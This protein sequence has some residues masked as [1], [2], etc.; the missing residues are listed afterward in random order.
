MVLENLD[1]SPV[2]A[3]EIAVRTERDPIMS[4]VPT[5]LNISDE[6]LKPYKSRKNELSVQDGCII[7]GLV[8]DIRLTNIAESGQSVIG[9]L[10]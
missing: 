9:G 8:L 7:W 10:D 5:W 6:D 3:T 4:K 2:S 1:D